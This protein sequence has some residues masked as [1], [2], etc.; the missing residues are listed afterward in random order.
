VK[1]SS[2]GERDYAFGQAML[3]LRTSIGLTQAELAEHLGVSRQAVGDWEAGRSYSKAHHLKHFILLCVRAS[4]FPA[5]REAE[6]IRA[7]WKAARQKVRL[8]EPWLSAL[9]SQQPPRSAPRPVGNCAESSNENTG[10]RAIASNIQRKKIELNVRTHF[11]CRAS[12]HATGHF[13]E[14]KR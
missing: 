5:G 2:Y 3:T 1:R 7:F 11:Q 12:F 14:E 10:L 9:L 13:S 4:A 8:D 6:E